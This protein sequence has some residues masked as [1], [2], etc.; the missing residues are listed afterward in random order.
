MVKL[1]DVTEE[2][3]MDDIMRGFYDRATDEIVWVPLDELDVA[4]E[5]EDG[6]DLEKLAGRTENG[7]AESLRLAV[8][9]IEG[10]FE[11]FIPLPSQRDVHEHAIME[12]F[13][14]DVL[15]ESDMRARIWRG[16]HRAGAFRSFKDDV[17]YFG[18]ADAW[19]QYR[20]MRFAEIAR[21]WAE[22]NN[23]PFTED[24]IADDKIQQL[25]DSL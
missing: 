20:D 19:Y 14:E 24:E 17:Q 12:D 4:E 9:V 3:G 5:F 23:V 1:A 21:E 18:L 15:P 13:V 22:E 10:Y 16:L 25:T 7:D 6:D 2:L 8:R 11:E